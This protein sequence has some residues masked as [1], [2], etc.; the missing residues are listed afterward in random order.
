VRSTTF[1]FTT[2][3]TSIQDFEKNA[4]KTWHIGT[5][6]AGRRRAAMLH[7]VRAV[8]LPSRARRTV[9]TRPEAELP[10]AA[11]PKGSRAPS[12][13][14][15]CPRRTALR[16]RTCRAYLRSKE[17]GAGPPIKATGILVARENHPTLPWP[18][19]GLLAAPVQAARQC[20]RGPPW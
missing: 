7:V 16:R 5:V 3:C 11:R 9:A 17:R 8:R 18:T 20:R 13:P 6:V 12:R 14:A 10:K 19:A 4:S 15:S 1:L 2:S